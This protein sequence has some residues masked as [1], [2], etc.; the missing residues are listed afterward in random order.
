MKRKLSRVVSL[1]FVAYNLRRRSSVAHYV[2]LLLLI[3]N[4]L[5]SRISRLSLANIAVKRVCDSRGPSVAYIK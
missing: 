5:F 2:D 4:S 3:E 1:F